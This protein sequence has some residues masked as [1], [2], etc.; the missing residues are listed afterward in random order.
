MNG[1]TKAILVISTHTSLA[2][3]DL[4]DDTVLRK[5]RISTHTSLAGRDL[6]RPTASPRLDDF[7]SHVPRGT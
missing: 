1:K 5:Y 4:R 3:R 6:S 7:Y 2:G